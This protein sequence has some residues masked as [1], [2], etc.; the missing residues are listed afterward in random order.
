MKITFKTLAPAGPSI[1]EAFDEAVLL[2]LARIDVVPRHRVLVGP[3]EDGATDEIR[4]VAPALLI[5][6]G[7][8]RSLQTAQRVAITG[9]Q[10]STMVLRK[11]HR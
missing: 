2:G 8:V 5:D 3:F 6:Y 4:P 10:V 9:S 1:H 11:P 7:H